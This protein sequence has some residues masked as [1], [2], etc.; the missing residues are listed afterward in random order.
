MSTPTSR[1]KLTPADYA[2]ILPSVLGGIMIIAF[3][4]GIIFAVRQLG[5]FRGV[6]M[7]VVASGLALLTMGGFA[8]AGSY[9]DD[10]F[11]KDVM[12]RLAGAGLGFVVLVVVLFNLA[13]IIL[14]PYATIR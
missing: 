11:G 12:F 1:D 4:T 5:F 3:G 14:G 2:R 9:L 13:P 6:L 7:I 8:A 10:R